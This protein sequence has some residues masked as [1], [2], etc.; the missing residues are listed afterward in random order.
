MNIVTAAGWSP[1]P[2]LY[3]RMRG[4]DQGRIEHRVAHW[5]GGS[6][7]FSGSLEESIAKLRAYERYHVDTK[8]WRGL[9]YDNAIDLA[10]RFFEIRMTGMSAATSGDYDEDG[11]PNNRE[12][13]ATLFLLGPGQKPSDQMVAAALQLDRSAVQLSGRWLGHDEAAGPGHTSCPGPFVMSDIVIPLREGRYRNEVP[14]DAMIFVHPSTGTPDAIGGLYALFLRPEQK[15]ALT[16]NVD[17]LKAA[18]RAGKRTY[19]VGG[20]A[21]DL[22][23][24]EKELKGTNRLD[25]AD[26]VLA[27]AR[28]GF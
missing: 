18:D 4:E 2:Q 13:D 11:V 21:C 17:T 23:A 3:E 16:A 22:V 6:H 5:P 15:V 7:T 19:A 10:G 14:V 12:T 25:T 26:K 20:P 9:A 1:R 8:G 28:K 27:Q 24:G